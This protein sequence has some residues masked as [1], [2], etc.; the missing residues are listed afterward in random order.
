MSA[1]PTSLKGPELEKAL[2]DAAAREERNGILTMGRYGVDGVIVQGKTML[3]PSKPDFEGVLSSG[4]Q[5]IIEAKCVAGPSFEMRKEKIKPRQISHMLTRSRH[6]VPC[7]LVIHFAERRLA[8][9]NFPAITVAIPVNDSQP[10][11]QAFVDAAA[12]AKREKTKMETQP[13]ITRDWAQEVGKLVP[14]ATPPRCKNALPDIISFLWPQLRQNPFLASSSECPNTPRPCS[15]E[16]VSPDL[17]LAGIGQTETAGGEH[18]SNS[19]DE[20][21]D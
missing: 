8:N 7:F 21:A 3:V 2:M 10:R 6:N 20:W 12:K 4:R 14:W 11:W 19:N 1:V 18:L 16:R 13:G 15:S 5:F 17:S 9:A